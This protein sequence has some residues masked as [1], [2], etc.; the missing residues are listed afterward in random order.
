VKRTNAD[1]DGFC[2]KVVILL[3]GGTEL[4][5][6][7]LT[8]IQPEQVVILL[9]GGTELKATPQIQ[10]IAYQFVVILLAGGTGWK[11]IVLLP[12]PRLEVVIPSSRRDW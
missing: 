7:R 5:P 8:W 4:K 1:A 2:K 3:A 9:A 6:G 10:S 11:P 12:T